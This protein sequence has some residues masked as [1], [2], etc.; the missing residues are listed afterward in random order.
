MRTRAR[1]CWPH[2]AKL[3]LASTLAGTLPPLDGVT[4]ALK[5]IALAQADACHAAG[6]GFTGKLCVHPQQI[7][8][9]VRGFTPQAEDIAWARKAAAPAQGA[10]QAGGLMVDTP[11]RL[12]AQAIL[13]RYERTAGAAL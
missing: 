13:D 7:Q 10:S 11:V 6:L 8:A 12:R 5:D 1:R 9:V 3:V 4:L 2:A